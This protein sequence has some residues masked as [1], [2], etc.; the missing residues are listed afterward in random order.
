MSQRREDEFAGPRDSPRLFARIARWYDLMNRLMSLGQDRRWRNLAADALALPPQGRVLD[1]G[2]GTG[3]MMLALLRRWPDATVVGVDPTR[4]MLQIGYRKLEVV[5]GPAQ[6]IGSTRSPVG[7]AQADGLYLPFPDEHFDA[8][9]SAFV[10]RNVV[11]VEQAL[12]EQRRVVQDGGRVGCL[13]MSWPST[14]PFSTLFHV[15]FADVMP[16]ITGLLSGQPAAYRY[17]PRSVQRFQTPEE[18]IRTMERVGLVDVRCRKVALGTV[19]L[20]IGTRAG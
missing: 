12:G 4:A 19:T 17:L 16:R 20:H 15:Y 18:L 10:L 14:P 1:V 8:A 3:D 7:W 6:P 11:D 2:T 9:V 13:E 5:S